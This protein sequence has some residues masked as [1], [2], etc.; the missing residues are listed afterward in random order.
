MRGQLIRQLAELKATD[1]Q[2]ARTTRRFNDSLNTV[3]AHYAKRHQV[4]VLDQKSTVA[5]GTDITHEIANQLSVVMR[6]KS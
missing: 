6:N 2:V 4:V 1:E 3:L 5:G